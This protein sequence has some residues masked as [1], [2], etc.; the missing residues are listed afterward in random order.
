MVSFGNAEFK[1]WLYFSHS[2]RVY[3]K[4]THAQFSWE[5]LFQYFSQLIR[6]MLSVGT[7]NLHILPKV[8]S[9]FKMDQRL[10]NSKV[11]KR[12]KVK[13]LWLSTKIKGVLTLL[14]I[15]TVSKALL[16]ELKATNKT[17]AW[18]NINSVWIT[19]KLIKESIDQRIQV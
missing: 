11:H 9:M 6:E 10:T 3:I 7:E 8:Q 2:T 4:F 18:N 1:Q 19:S 15:M 5:C 14:D 16:W 17:V 12:I 13:S